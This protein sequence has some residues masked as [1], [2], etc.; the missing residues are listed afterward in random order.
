MTPNNGANPLR[1]DCKRQGCFNA[2]K[3]PKIEMFAECLPGRGS[4]GDVDAIAELAGNLLI[5]EWKSHP[6]IP[7]GQRILHE[8]WTANGPATV[9][10][11]VGN[12]ERSG[13][14]ASS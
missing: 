5:L 12:G 13:K 8:Q 14:A 7:T 3:R 2:V 4:F 11:I 9:F 1:W 10:V 6:N